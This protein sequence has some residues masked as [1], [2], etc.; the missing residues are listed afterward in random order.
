MNNMDK[1]Q[2]ICKLIRYYILKSTTLAGS[3]HPTSSLS[4]VELT[5]GL[6]FG[7]F[8]KYRVQDP[9]F[10][11][12][13]RL[14]FSKGHASPLLYAL[15]TVAGAIKEE[16][17]WQLR[18][19]ESN[20]EGHPTKSFK[21]GEAATGSLG[22][23]LSIGV[24][25]AL[26]AK[27]LDMLPYKTFVLL[28][29]SE[30]AEGSIWEAVQLAS[31]YHLDNLVG[32][33]DVNGLGQ[34]GWTMHGHQTQAYAD[35]LTSFGW[36]T[37]QINGHNLEEVL[38]AYNAAIDAKDKPVMIIAKTS[39]GKGISFLADKLGWHGKALNEKQLREALSELGEIKYKITAELNQP[40]DLQPYQANK[41][42]VPVIALDQN[43][44]ATRKAYGIGLVNIFHRFPH[45]VALDGEVSNSTYSET[46][47]NHYPNHY[48]EMFIA[49]QNMVGVALGLSLRGKIPF[50][51]S[52][53]AFLTRAFDQIRMSQYSNSNIK[54]IGSHAGVSIGEDG[55]SQ[56]G[57]EDIAMFRTNLEGVVLYPSDAVSTVKLIEQAAR[58]KGNVYIRT[59]R[60]DTPIIYDQDTDF[61]IG[62][63][64]TV[65]SSPQDQVTVCAAGITLHQ[66][67]KA[68][69]S[70]KKEG[71]AIRIVDVYS[72]KP[73]DYPALLKAQ[74]ETKAIITV[75]D[76]Y[77][78]GGLGEAVL[79]ALSQHDVPIYLMAVEKMP[80][81]GSPKQL[82]DF[83]GISSQ[84]IV[85]QVKKI[86]E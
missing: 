32:I 78:E 12:N 50:V 45:I 31:H 85:D 65:K 48:F 35:L 5:A 4:A 62:G 59:T 20:L 46:F 52:F 25:M 80:K 73:V 9:D 17:L 34:S 82:M 33:I 71:I 3:G 22:Q 10:A 14:I 41:N 83:E 38:G 77:R 58:H 60:M 16:Q 1:L 42:N 21:Y 74:Q 63:S 23:G 40:E 18:Q 39:K 79:S 27:Y 86:V 28:G 76:H 30:M 6:M 84:A 61:I 68:Y 75:E 66:A 15:W 24:G 37:I 36:Q 8:F 55:P 64:Q 67:V 44:M 2:E 72:I 51:S 69:Y 13:D 19:F 47:K 57:L 26:N 29:D 81:S 56:M 11:N 43:K 53:A 54:F 70:L 49:E 7:G